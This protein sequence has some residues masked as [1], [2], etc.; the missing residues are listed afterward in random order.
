MAKKGKKGT[1]RSRARIPPLAVGAG[2]VMSAKVVMDALDNTTLSKGD[3]LIALLTGYNPEAKVWTA[4]NLIPV[5]GPTVAG[6]VAHEV[7]GNPRGAFGSGIGA[8]INRYM[9]GLRI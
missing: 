9:K 1:R 4:D 7:I 2:V 8:K 6:I 3:A 5:Y